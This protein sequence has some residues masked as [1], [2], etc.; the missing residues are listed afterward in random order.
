MAQPLSVN[1]YPNYAMTLIGQGHVTATPDLALIRLGVQTTGSNLFEIQSENAQASQRVIQA[2]GQLGITEI[3]TIQY[4]IDKMYDYADGKQIDKGYS[5]QNIVEIKT[6]NIDQVGNII[7]TAVNM[8]S[9]VVTSISFTLSEPELYYQ[10][11]LNL[12]VDNAIQKA[13]TISANLHVRL[14][15]IPIRIIEGSASPSPMQQLKLDVAAT[16]IIP[17]DLSIEA[18]VTADFFYI[19]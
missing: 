11:A 18:F 12:A 2:L 13:K 9:N 5:V 7:D 19:K 4:S 8:G 14:N 3:K 10:N 6:N 16:P 1:H 17:G 15:P